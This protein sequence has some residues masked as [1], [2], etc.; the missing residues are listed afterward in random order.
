MAPYSKKQDEN[1][2]KLEERLGSIENDLGKN[3]S[4]V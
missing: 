3:K 4:E 1:H 2:A